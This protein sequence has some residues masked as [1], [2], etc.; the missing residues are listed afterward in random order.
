MLIGKYGIKRYEVNS[1]GKRISQV[2]YIK[3]T[4]G[5]EVKIT[6]DLEVQ[7]YAQ[8]IIHLHHVYRDAIV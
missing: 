6:I 5:R 7:K 3:E 4:Q 8:E 1:S 2:D